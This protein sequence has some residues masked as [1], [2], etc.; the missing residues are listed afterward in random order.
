MHIESDPV[1]GHETLLQDIDRRTGHVDREIR[2]DRLTGHR[3][4]EDSDDSLTGRD[5]R[6]YDPHTG[7]MKTEDLTRIDGAVLHS[8]VDAKT[9]HWTTAARFRD[10]SSERTEQFSNGVERTV[11]SNGLTEVRTV[12]RDGQPE[13]VYGLSADGTLIH[14]VYRPGTSDPST[15]DTTRSDGTTEHMV[16]AHRRPGVEGDVPPQS[17]DIRHPNGS[18]DHVDYDPR[19]GHAS[20]VTERSASGVERHFKIDAANG[21][22]IPD[23]VQDALASVYLAN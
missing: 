9:G 17:K 2:Y 10:G 1:T 18:T 23:P 6:V 19:T 7:K 11:H 3:L 5:H 22:A 14:S 4:S 13:T 20:R 8:A 12:D 21:R 15:I 16:Y